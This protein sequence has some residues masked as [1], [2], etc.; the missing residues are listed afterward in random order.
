MD[1][2]GSAALSLL[3]GLLIGAL[4]FPHTLGISR[5]RGQ[6]P[7]PEGEGA[8]AVGMEDMREYY[9]ALEDMRDGLSR[10]AFDPAAVV[11]RVGRDP[12]DLSEWV[13]ERIAWI[14]Y[15]GHLRSPSAVMMDGAGNSLDRAV[16][17]ARLLEMAGHEPRLAM[18]GVEAEAWAEEVLPRVSAGEAVRAPVEPQSMEVPEVIEDPSH[19]ALFHEHISHRQTTLMDTIRRA[20]SQIPVFADKVQSTASSGVAAPDLS[21]VHWWV[22]VDM[23]EETLRL[24]PTDAP[25][26]EADEVVAWRDFPEEQHQQVD[27]RI[28]VEQWK[29][30]ERTEKEVLHRNFRAA[31]IGNDHLR[32]GFLPENVSL[33]FQ[34]F[35][36][37]PEETFRDFV[38]ALR[39]NTLWVPYVQVGEEMETDFAFTASG[40]VNRDHESSA[41]GSAMRE[42]S[43]LLGGLG[44]NDRNKAGQGRLTRVWMELSTSGPGMETQTTER[45]LYGPGHD[46]VQ[47][48]M[49]EQDEIRRGLALTSVTDV[50]VQ[51]SVLRRSY[52]TARALDHELRNRNALLGA[53]HY[54][55]KGDAGKLQASMEKL[56]ELPQI[57]YD[58]A[59]TRWM[60]NPHQEQLY[61]ARPHLLAWHRGL[62]LSEEGEPVLVR[63]LDL[64]QISAETL[65][66]V[67]SPRLRRMEQGVL[68]SVLES[69]L[70]RESDGEGGSASELLE[71]IPAEEWVWV[72]SE[73]E[74]DQL[75]GEWDPKVRKGVLRALERGES[76]FAPGDLAALSLQEAAW[77]E[78]SP[79]TGHTK[80]RIAAGGWG[81]KAEYVLNLYVAKAALTM[82][83]VSAGLCYEDPSFSCIACNFSAGLLIVAGIFAPTEKV[84]AAVVIANIIAN[85]G[86]GIGTELL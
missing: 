32:I 53:L 75:N 86:C 72:E 40:E 6:S 20:Q 84:T 2:L 69:V 5:A 57:L 8:P 76:V 43:G 41:Q 79:A 47:K 46:S 37:Q 10:E 4:A 28:R 49:S 11:A 12:S 55:E 9:S 83:A 42:A 58:F 26:R 50:L 70:L 44:G 35:Q 7:A 33:E 21:G 61:I 62:Q 81:G 15:A 51:T 66:G 24:D 3:Y 82:L 38:E 29:E 19:R 52:L 85:L 31:A 78:F 16:L 34:R 27:V 56:T 68:D 14:P 39:A 25:E 64:M 65:P 36:E 22:E 23:E 59:L 74:L 18:A 54:T 60:L 73:E 67:S 80:G 13:K 45:E 17:L 77:W 63:G 71:Q 30:G 1:R 48:E